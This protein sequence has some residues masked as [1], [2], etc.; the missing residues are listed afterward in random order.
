MTNYYYKFALTTDYYTYDGNSA[1]A[2]DHY[3]LSEFSGDS[4]GTARVADWSDLSS[5]GITDHQA[6]KDVLNITSSRAIG[7]CSDQN[8]SVNAGNK[9]YRATSP[10]YRGYY[11][12][13]SI[14]S[15]YGSGYHRINSISSSP[16]RNIKVGSWYFPP[17]SSGLRVLVYFPNYQA[18][19]GHG[20]LIINGSIT[21]TW[22]STNKQFSSTDGNTTLS[23]NGST[24]VI[25]L[26]NGSPLASSLNS[27]NVPYYVDPTSSSITWQGTNTSVSVPSTGAQGD[28]HINPILGNPYTI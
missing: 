25:D 22:D 12:A 24:W 18:N 9:F 28:P 26:N 4:R 1:I 11:S 17:P 10:K 6:L 5:L 7:W 23:H 13:I 16:F 21:T 8:Y 20:T 14:G 19:G 27:S 15:D 2:L 3:D